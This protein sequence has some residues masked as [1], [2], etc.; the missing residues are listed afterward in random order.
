[1][2]ELKLSHVKCTQ[3]YPNLPDSEVKGHHTL[4]H[5][6]L[7]RGSALTS[8]WPPSPHILLIRNTNTRSYI[9][10]TAER[11][12]DVI[13]RCELCANY[14]YQGECGH[15]KSASVRQ[16][17]IGKCLRE[18]NEAHESFK[19]LICSMRQTRVSSG[20][21]GGCYIETHRRA[22]SSCLPL[23]NRDV[24]TP[25]TLCLFIQRAIY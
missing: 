2:L 9:V 24:N 3:R 23:H 1:M 17:W 10:Q 20:R 21:V 15:R 11:G 14:C 22:W 4:F 7:V 18:A 8:R 6:V 19:C 25:M 5:R 13:A 16:R 12:G